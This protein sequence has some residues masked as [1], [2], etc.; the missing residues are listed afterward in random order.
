[1]KIVKADFNLK[2]IEFHNVGELEEYESIQGLGMSRFPAKVREVMTER[3]KFIAME[4]VGCEIRFYTDSPN[5]RVHL[6]AVSGD[7]LVWVY[8][9]D[10]W[11][12]TFNLEQG[13]ISCLQVTKTDFSKYN[14]EYLNKGAFSPEIWRFIIGGGHVAFCGVETFG[15]P[16]R[17]PK[18]SEKPKKKWLA[19][20][21][22]IT[23]ADLYGYAHTAARILGVDIFNKGMSGACFCEKETANYLAEECDWDFATLELGVN[24]R[25]SVEPA[26]FAKRSQYIVE[27]FTTQK[28]GKPVILINTFPNGN[29]ALKI[30]DKISETQNEYRNIIREIAS[31]MRSKNV[32]LIEGN[33]I[34]SDFTMLSVDLVHPTPPGHTLMGQNLAEKLK[35]IINQ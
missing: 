23:H 20:G 5:V 2:K 31:E 19:Y 33:E 16:I 32:H 30:P 26:E 24:M 9:G 14:E 1:M 12:S 11:N 28:K 34:L 4:S 7:P 18:P 13:K 15:H 25:N 21:S 17:P 6:N 29:D 35:K 10:I 8:Q 27:T 3:G 22:S